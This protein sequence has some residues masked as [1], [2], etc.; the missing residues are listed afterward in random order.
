MDSEHS[1]TEEVGRVRGWIRPETTSA[2][3][4]VLQTIPQAVERVSENISQGN[5]SLARRV[6]RG[7]YL[8]YFLEQLT[9]EG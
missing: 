9:V 5:T 8:F 2:N 1:G 7:Q 6:I 3:D 4:K